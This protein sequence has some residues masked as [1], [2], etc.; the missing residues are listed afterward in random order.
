MA[1]TWAD[2]LRDSYV[3]WFV[4]NI[5]A[6]T[7]LVKAGSPTESMARIALQAGAMLAGLDCRVWFERVPSDDNPADVLSLAAVDDPEVAQDLVNGKLVLGP[8]VD[9]GHFYHLDFHCLWGWG[10]RWLSADE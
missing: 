2:R 5:S 10:S 4:D 8:P 6:N 9:I 1:A 7:A 3:I